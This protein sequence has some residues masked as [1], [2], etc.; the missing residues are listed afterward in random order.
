MNRR[1]LGN[2]YETLAAQFLSEQGFDVLE[3]NIYTPVG[4]LDI[5]AARDSVYYFFEVRYKSGSKCGS[6]KQ[7]IT[8]TKLLRMKRTL[9][10]IKKQRKILS[11]C[12]L[13]FVGINT[14]P[15][16]SKKFE[17]IAPIY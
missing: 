16:G 4:E 8:Q 1:R 7:S 2:S 10:Y 9:L 6:P 15:D 13:G 14:L 17:L 5:L 3:R 11:K 12:S